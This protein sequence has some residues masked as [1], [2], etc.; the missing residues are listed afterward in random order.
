MELSCRTDHRG[1]I[2]FSLLDA[3]NFARA[4]WNCGTTVT[5][6]IN[7]KIDEGSRLWNQKK[8]C[9]LV[10]KFYNSPRDIDLTKKVWMSPTYLREK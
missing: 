8:P 2:L 6:M 4:Y 5:D 1:T 9:T 10:R 3:S 7:T